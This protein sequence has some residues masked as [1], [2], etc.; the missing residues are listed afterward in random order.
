MAF[1]EYGDEAAVPQW[2]VTFGD[3]MSLLLTFFIM[4]V[5]MSDVSSDERYQAV[6]ETMARRFGQ[7]ASSDSMATGPLRPRD[8]QIA[9]VVAAGRSKRGGLHSQRDEFRETAA[10]QLRVGGIRQSHQT[11]FGGFVVFAADSDQ[12]TEVNKAHLQ[13]LAAELAGKSQMIDICGYISRQSAD[14]LRHRENW[15]LAYNRCRQTMEFLVS[16]GIE[17]GRFRVGVAAANEPKLLPQQG[18]SG[19]Q[20]TR[21][22][23]LLLSE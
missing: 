12:L 10:D 1:D 14:G 5:S 17:P 8:R 16:I 15:D 21:V 19:Q 3:M 9:K 13:T 22:D 18:V 11:R 6:V 20:N 7:H 23:V 4:L 2:M